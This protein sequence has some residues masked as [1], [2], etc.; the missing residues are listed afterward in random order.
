MVAVGRRPRRR[1]RPRC[2]RRRRG[3][4]A[5]RPAGP[6]RRGR[7]ARACPGLR[8]PRGSR[9]SF[10]ATS[11]SKA[12]AEGVGHEPAPVD[13][14]AV[15]VADGSAVGPHRVHDDAP[16]RG[17]VPLGPRIR[18]VVD[19]AVARRRRLGHAAGEGE[20]E[21]GAVDVGVATGGP[22]RPGC[23]RSPC[24]AATH[25]VVER[26]QRRPA[27]PR[28]RW[29]RPRCRRG[30]AAPGPRR[31]CGAPPT[32][33]R[34]PR[35]GAPRRAGGALGVDDGQRGVEEAG[36]G[37]VEDDERRSGRRRRSC[38]PLSAWS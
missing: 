15:V 21:A 12:R 26:G 11:T 24:S 33:P 18:G 19:S 28:S 9:A 2:R 34:A 29:C 4:R 22:R 25:G 31:R 38:G 10:T 5:S 27:A 23:R 1:A 20:V 6:R 17:V 8:M 37:L 14:D 35:R 13:A 7:G 16:G 30:T 36:V 32:A 3:C